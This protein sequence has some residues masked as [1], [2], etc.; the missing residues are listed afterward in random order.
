MHKYLLSFLGISALATFALASE[1]EQNET[2]QR[3]FTLSGPAARKLI[4]D[5]I[6]GSIRV[7]G[8]SGNDVRMVAHRHVRAD[9]TEKAEEARRDIKID[10]SQTANTVQLF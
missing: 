8:Q 4:V 3:T 5:N 10:M 1:V 2:I 6:S 7:T 9:S